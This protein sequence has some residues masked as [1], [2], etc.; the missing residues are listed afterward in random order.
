[1][2]DLYV[3]EGNAF[4]TLFSTLS[5]GNFHHHPMVAA[6]WTCDSVSR[7]YST[8][9]DNIYPLGEI[10]WVKTVFWILALTAETYL[11]ALFFGSF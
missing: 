7:G 2:L 4:D 5:S 9:C 1:M 10:M 3:P 6:K 8:Y 11:G